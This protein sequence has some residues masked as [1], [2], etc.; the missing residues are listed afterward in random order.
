MICG[1]YTMW[2]SEDYFKSKY[3]HIDKYMHTVLEI[4]I[5]IYLIYQTIRIRTKNYKIV[6]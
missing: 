1:H 3:T 5:N 2:K 6:I 4:D